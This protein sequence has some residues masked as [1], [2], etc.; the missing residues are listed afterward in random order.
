MKNVYVIVVFILFNVSLKAQTKLIISYDASGNQMQREYCNG[1]SSR[2]ASQIKKTDSLNVVAKEESLPQEHPVDAIAIL[3]NPTQGQL[4]L[5]WGTDLA[6]RIQQIKILG[7][8][9]PFQKVIPYQ[10]TQQ[11][12]SIDLS[13]EP[14]SIY[15]VQFY[16]QDGSLITK[17]IIK[18]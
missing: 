5:S 14:S 15:I 9:T 7:Y 6:K 10:S 18:K 11:T 12:V 3:P 4:V 2:S 8:H 16:L 1:C 17:K 13:R